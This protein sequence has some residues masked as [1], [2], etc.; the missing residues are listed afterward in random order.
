MIRDLYQQYGAGTYKITFDYKGSSSKTVTAGI[1]IDH[2]DKSKSTSCSGTTSWT[3]KTWSVTLS[4]DPADVDQ[5]ALWF[6]IASGYSVSIR[7]LTITKT[8]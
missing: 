7:N 1:G 4:N 5:M 8:N 6:K 2:T 3:T